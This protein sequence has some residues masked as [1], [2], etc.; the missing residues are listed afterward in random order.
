MTEYIKIFQAAKS[1]GGVGIYTRRLVKALDK[2]QY[3][4]TVACL[5]EGSDEMA[6][7][8]SQLEGVTAISIPMR[9]EIAPLS[10]LWVFY[11]LMKIIRSEKFDLLHVHTSKPGFMSRLAALG[12]GVPVI[13]QPANF[14]FHDGMPRKQAAFYA[15]LERFAAQYLT[16]RIIAVCNGEREM[17]RRFSVG[18]DDQFVTIHTGIELEPFEVQVNRDCVRASLGVPKNAFL[19]GTV[20]RLTEAKAPLDLIRAAALV[21]ERMPDVHFL[22]VGD[23]LLLNQSRELVHAL[24]IESVFH[25]P[26]F[27]EDIPAI[28]KS[29]NCFV[30]SSHWEGFALSILEAMAARLPVV[31]TRVMG[32]SEAVDD[33][34]TGLLTPIGDIDALAGAIEKIVLDPIL[35]QKL[36]SAG[37]VRVRS[38]FPFT[39]MIT[40]IEEL[41]KELCFSKAYD[42]LHRKRPIQR[43]RVVKGMKEK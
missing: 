40:R 3:R 8:L 15:V 26:G 18:S 38:E 16:D 14:A 36:G 43:L 7:E 33:G 20:A 11:R 19:V 12:T 29:M 21:H 41:Y 1:I 27:R 22:W 28:L 31:S 5:A 32:A 30:L 37:F 34:V 13:Y 17:A 42:S 39:K 4:I 35:A 9:D 2:E 10:D 24:G 6:D 25:F 23:G